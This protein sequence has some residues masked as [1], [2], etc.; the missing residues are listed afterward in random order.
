MASGVGEGSAE[1][2]PEWGQTKSART[3]MAIRAAKCHAVEHA[4][5]THLSHSGILSFSA[6]DGSATA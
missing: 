4:A 2:R 1:G 5:D 6:G 3:A